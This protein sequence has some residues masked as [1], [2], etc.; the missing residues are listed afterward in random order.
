MNERKEIQR[1][2][3]GGREGNVEKRKGGSKGGRSF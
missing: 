2:G 3:K 1:K